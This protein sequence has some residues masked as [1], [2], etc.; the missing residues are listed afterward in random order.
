MLAT[1]LIP[2][3]GLAATIK[4]YEKPSDTAKVTGTVDLSAGIIPIFTPENSPWIKVAN[5]QNGETGWVKNTDL[6]DSKGNAISFSQTIKENSGGTVQSTQMQYG[7]PPA[8]PTMP[9]NLDNLDQKQKEAT[10]A[11]MKDPRVAPALDA[12]KQ[13]YELQIKALQKAGFPTVK[14][15]VTMPGQAPAEQPA[16]VPRTN[17]NTNTPPT[18][19]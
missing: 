7:K 19:Q 6:K 5:P 12:M 1:L 17:T 15:I 18:T 4:L 10:E 2:V 14:P 13:A 8:M 3:V 9:T 16:M 11:L